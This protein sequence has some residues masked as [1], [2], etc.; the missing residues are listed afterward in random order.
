MERLQELS[1]EVI[2]I[3]LQQSQMVA[4]S[5]QGGQISPK[6][7]E[8][9]IRKSGVKTKRMS[10]LKRAYYPQDGALL[11]LHEPNC[12][13]EKICDNN[14]KS[15]KRTRPQSEYKARK[16]SHNTQNHLNIEIR[17]IQD[18]RIEPPPIVSEQ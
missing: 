4:T 16:Q 5:S 18:I 9:R 10:M 17:P 2:P 8:F 1:M 6:G 14:K 3:E 11:M 12:L 7:S 13:Q 15:P